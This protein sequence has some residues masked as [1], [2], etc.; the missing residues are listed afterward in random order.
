VERLATQGHYRIGMVHL[1]QG[2]ARAAI[3]AFNAGLA[4][5]PT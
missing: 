2:N 1:K 5:D 4:T 3:D